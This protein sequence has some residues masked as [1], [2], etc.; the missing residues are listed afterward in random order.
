MQKETTPSTGQRSRL[1]LGVA[2]PLI[3]I[4]AVALILLATRPLGGEPL[5]S[6]Y[7]IGSAKPGVQ[8]G[9]IAPGT[10]QAH[11]SPK[12]ALTDPDGAPVDLRDFVGHPIWIIFWKTAC[13]P[14]EAEAADVAAAYAVQR[15]AG[16]VLLGIDVWDSAAAVRDWAD[17][18]KLDYPIAIDS[19]SS[20]MDTFGVW[21]APTHYFIGS[22]GIIRDRYFGPMTSKLI[23][24]SLR[25]IMPASTQ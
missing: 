20:V 5:P 19:S 7:V 21:G 9:Q 25:T 4:G 24:K 14:C 6:I 12:L 10:V 3:V 1:P 23:D 22:D 11:D 17:A 16:L 18:H 13:A 8:I 2:L 15:D